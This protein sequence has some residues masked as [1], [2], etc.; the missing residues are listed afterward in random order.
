[1]DSSSKTLHSFVGVNAKTSLV[2][3]LTESEHQNLLIRMGQF[4]GLENK[5][6]CCPL[7]KLL[8]ASSTETQAK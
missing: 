8:H 6:Q 3:S 2:F 4:F 1:M 7:L 5:K